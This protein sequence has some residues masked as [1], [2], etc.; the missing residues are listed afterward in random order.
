MLMLIKRLLHAI[1]MPVF[2][3]LS[4]S[5]LAQ[6]RVVTGKV[7]DSKDGSAIA[8]ASVQPK[9]SKTGTST[10]PD[11]SFSVAVPSGVNTLLISSAEFDQQEV[12]I[13]G[14]PSIDV[15][16][17]AK[18]SGLTEVVVI[19]YGTARKKDLT[20][21]VASVQAKDFNKGT[22][23]SPDQ[24]IQGKAAGV[25]VINNT[26]QPGGSTTVRIRGSSSIR[27]GNQPLFVVDGVPLAGGSARP[28]SQGGEFGSDGGNPLN[29]LNP[30]DISSMEILKD[31]SAT[32]IYGSRGANGVI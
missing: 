4:L 14:R 21:A 12:D 22:Y 13:T 3:T 18:A 16:L 23:T 19:G 8:G 15:A 1:F 11:G 10:G 30:N 29:Y 2:L 20:G 5:M 25:L 24:L 7:T 26:G 27:S 9:G 6:D 28:G 17:V 31:A 32:A